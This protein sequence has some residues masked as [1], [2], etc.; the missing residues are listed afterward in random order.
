MSETTLTYLYLT[1]AIVSE[2]TA[3]STLKATEQF[4]KL[5]PSLIVIIGYVISFFFLSLTLKICLRVL[6]MLF[7][8]A[9]VL[10]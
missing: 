5:M 1:L 3:T 7:G 6:L 9:L 2:V 4:T 10:F 8:L